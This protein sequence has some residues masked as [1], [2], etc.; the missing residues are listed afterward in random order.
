[1]N[2]IFSTKIGIRDKRFI[3]FV[4]VTA[5]VV[6]TIIIH[7]LFRYWIH[8][9]YRIAGLQIITPG[10]EKWNTDLVFNLSKIFSLSFLDFT[11]TDNTFFF[12]NGYCVIINSSCSGIKQVLQFALL[13]AIYPGPWKH[14]AWFIPAGIILVYITT[15]IRIAGLC[16]VMQYWPDHWHFAHDYPFRILFYLVIFLIWVFWNERFYHPGL[17]TKIETK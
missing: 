13:I 2:K 10:F 7:Y 11:S 16:T 8:F 17:K 14:K 5:F 15:V 1:M 9:D 12:K 6:L 3:I 4:E